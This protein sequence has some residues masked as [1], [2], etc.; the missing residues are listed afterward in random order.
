LYEGLPVWPLP[1]ILV[2]GSVLLTWVYLQT[3]S[4]LLAGVT[5]ASLNGTV[6]LTWGLDPAWVWQARGITLPV[7]AVVIIALDQAYRR[8]QA[9]RPTPTAR[10]A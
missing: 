7:L 10:L 2:S 4:V 1:L 6:P 9:S 3:G 5:H 8:L